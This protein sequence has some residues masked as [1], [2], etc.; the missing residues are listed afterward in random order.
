MILTVA[1]CLLVIVVFGLDAF[2]VAL[3]AVAQTIFWLLA[4][5]C[6]AALLAGLWFGFGKAAAADPL[7]IDSVMVI[8]TVAVP[9]IGGFWYVVG[10]GRKQ[11]NQ[12]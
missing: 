10:R 1:I 5:C 4:L 12:G 11:G 7:F 8:V 6:V 2:L 9:I 3:M